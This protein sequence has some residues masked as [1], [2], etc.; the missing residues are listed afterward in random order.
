LVRIEL[1]VDVVRFEYDVVV[2]AELSSNRRYYVK[3]AVGIEIASAEVKC[4]TRA[5]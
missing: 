4:E 2:R 1:D 5:M 3:R